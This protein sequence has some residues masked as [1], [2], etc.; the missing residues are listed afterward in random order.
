MNSLLLSLTTMQETYQEKY[1]EFC[2]FF[3]NKDVFK[4]LGL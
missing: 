3:K 4:S 1:G 2:P